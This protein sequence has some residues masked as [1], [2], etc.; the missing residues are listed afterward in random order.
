MRDETR[1]RR[2][3]EARELLL[4]ILGGHGRALNRR[5]TLSDLQPGR[6][7]QVRP[8]GKRHSHWRHAQW[9]D[10]HERSLA[11][12]NRIPNAFSL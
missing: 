10:T 11:I 4:R 3:L 12:S 5:M 8:W 9:Y 1:P 6:M 7:A 2:A